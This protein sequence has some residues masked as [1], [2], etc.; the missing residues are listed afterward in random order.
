MKTLCILVVTDSPL[1]SVN[2]DRVRRI[3]SVVI[4]AKVGGVDCV[5]VAC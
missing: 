1:G 3:G 4:V 2:G 5:R